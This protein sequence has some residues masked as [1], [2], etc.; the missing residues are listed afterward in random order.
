MPLEERAGKQFSSRGLSSSKEKIRLRF[1]E[2]TQIN[3]TPKKM[4]A[5][6]IKSLYIPR[7]VC[8]SGISDCHCCSRSLLKQLVLCESSWKKRIQ[9]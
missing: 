4:S 6:K 5:T 9:Y 2:P 3:I 8:E 1:T 7:H